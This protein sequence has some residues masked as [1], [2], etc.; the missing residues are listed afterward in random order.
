MYFSV[1]TSADFSS[2]CEAVSDAIRDAVLVVLPAI[3]LPIKL[4]GAS[5]VFGLLFWSSLN[6]FV[7]DCLA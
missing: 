6:A 5:A 2:V 3:L 1:G 7:A 4:S